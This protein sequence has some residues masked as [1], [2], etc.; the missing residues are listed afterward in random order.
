MI[1]DAVSVIKSLNMDEITAKPISSMYIIVEYGNGEL[2]KIGL[3]P[4][5]AREIE[6]PAPA[7]M[8]TIPK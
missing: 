7:K 6:K 1:Q 4:N 3:M 5:K 2:K 8:V